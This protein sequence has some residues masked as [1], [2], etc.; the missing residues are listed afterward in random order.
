LNNET[1][2]TI[3]ESFIRCHLLYGL[4]AWGGAKKQ[5]IKPLEKSLAKTWKKFGGRQIHTLNRLKN[6]NILKLEDELIIQ[7]CKFLHRWEKNL[8]SSLV[9]LI[10]EKHDRLRG[11]RFIIPRNLKDNSVRTRLGKIA[12]I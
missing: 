3:Y 5:M 8:P 11:R 4:V 7:E 2:K 10:N 6:N 1:K 12:N 9:N